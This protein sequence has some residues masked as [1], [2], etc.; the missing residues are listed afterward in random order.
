MRHLIAGNWKMH[1]LAGE[2]EEIAAIAA[3]A[4]TTP[5]S[6]VSCLPSI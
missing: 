1:G 6:P 3:A 4:A 2:L 5:A